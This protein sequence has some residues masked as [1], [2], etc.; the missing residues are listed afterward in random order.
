MSQQNVHTACRSWEQVRA[1]IPYELYDEDVRIDNMPEWPIQ[2]PYH[3]H[4]G[5]R[6]W[7]ADLSDVFEDLQFEVDE[8]YDLDEERV[9]TVVTALA[10]ATHTRIPQQ[11]QWASL[12]TFKDGRI[13]RAQ[14]YFTRAQAL[15]AVG[16]S[17]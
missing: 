3:G 8:V 2:G 13:V 12:L 14:G 16:L 4:E 10:T 1:E 5:L 7:W 11:H 17:E 15:E 9:L 6:Q